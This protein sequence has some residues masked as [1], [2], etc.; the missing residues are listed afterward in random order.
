M[1]VP[2][3]GYYDGLMNEKGACIECTT[4]IVIPHQLPHIL[5]QLHTEVIFVS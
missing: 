2:A 5:Q 3:S 4:Q 1:L